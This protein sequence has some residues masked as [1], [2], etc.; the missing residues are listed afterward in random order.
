M[1]EVKLLSCMNASDSELTNIAGI[2]TGTMG[3]ANTEK[4][5]KTLVIKDHSSVF[6]HAVFTFYVKCPIFVARQIIRHRMASYTERSSRYTTALDYAPIKWKEDS[7][8]DKY[9]NN[10]MDKAYEAYNAAVAI[11]VPKEIARQALPQA[12]LTEFIWTINARSLLNFLELRTSPHAQKEIR[13]LAL[14]VEKIF[15]NKMPLLHKYWKERR[16]SE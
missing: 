16:K 15:A 10:A 5:M 14:E 9:L 8:V 4:L 11:G 3:Q 2:S 7:D 6:E 13:E 12:Q 1:S